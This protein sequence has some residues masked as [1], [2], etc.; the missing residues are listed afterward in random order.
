VRRF[1]NRFKQS[2]FL[3]A[4]HP[5]EFWNLC[6]S[7]ETER[8]KAITVPDG[9]G[10]ADWKLNDRVQVQG[11]EGFVFVYDTKFPIYDTPFTYIVRPAG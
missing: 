11:R 3:G 2:G 7:S 4:T 5:I 1:I 10:E 8:F 9:V 6:E